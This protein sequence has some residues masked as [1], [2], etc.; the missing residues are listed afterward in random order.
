[1]RRRRSRSRFAELDGSG[2]A[3]EE[4]GPCVLPYLVG[5]LD[6]ASDELLDPLVARRRF[7]LAKKASKAR[8]GRSQWRKTINFASEPTRYRVRGRLA[9]SARSTIFATRYAGAAMRSCIGD[10]SR[11]FSIACL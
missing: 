8:S 1:M 3:R 4:L 10:A 5:S 6:F 7:I 11:R 9:V 2:L